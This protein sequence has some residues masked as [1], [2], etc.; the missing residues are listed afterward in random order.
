[1]SCTK[2][3][4]NN[5]IEYIDNY[6]IWNESEKKSFFDKIHY[7]GYIIRDL[8]LLYR[9]T[10]QEHLKLLCLETIQYISQNYSF[11]GKI[12]PLSANGA[13]FRDTFARTIRLQYE[14]YEYLREPYILD[15][16]EYQVKKWIESV[17]RKY[18]NGYNIFPYGIDKTGNSLV[19]EIDPNQNLV[20]AWLFTELYFCKES[21]FYKNP[22][23][24]DI[25]KEEVNAAL[26]LM[27]S[28]GEL[29]LSESYIKCFDSNYG[30]YSSTILYGI[31]QIW[32]KDEWIM[33]IKK[34][35][36]WLYSSFPI[37]HPWNMKDDYP[38]WVK[39]RHYPSNLAER[40]PAFYLSGIEI[41][42]NRK[43]VD[44]II[45]LFPEYDNQLELKFF[46]LK[47]I[48][49]KYCNES[50]LDLVGYDEP[51]IALI[52][53]SVRIIWRDIN[54]IQVNN[55]TYNIKSRIDVIG[56]PNTKITIYENMTNRSYT[57]VTAEGFNKIMIIDYSHPMEL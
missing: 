33:A 56:F 27:T 14:A 54:I 45:R 9:L 2:H 36:N 23:F 40:I 35:G 8:A 12:I 19:Y 46:G 26:S 20:L 48:P 34:M 25:V 30:G 24:Q 31:A 10:N 42:Y 28:S 15:V 52:N 29:P 41:D 51:K 6:Y 16:I 11:S 18:H 53:N 5:V 32:G 50:Y 17:P 44:N 55:K 13:W 3:F 21:K 38:N 22:L 37:N 47:S 49:P 39:D 57:Y 7:F 43:W 1:M 4:D